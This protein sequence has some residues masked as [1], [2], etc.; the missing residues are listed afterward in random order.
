MENETHICPVCNERKLKLVRNC[1]NVYMKTCGD[2]LCISKKT[3][4]ENFRKYGS[5]NGI[6][7]KKLKQLIIE[8][9]GVEN[10]S[11]IQ[12]IKQKKIET[13]LK[14]FGVE[15]PM[16]SSVV[17]D[18]SKKTIMK[19]YGVDNISKVPEIIE[20]I[21][22]TTHIIDPLT[23]M[24]PYQLGRLKIKIRC[25]EKYGTE[26]YYQTEEFKNKY[27]K[28]MMSKYGVDNYSK[29]KEFGEFLISSGLK[30]D[31]S[32]KTEW[33]KYRYSCMKY[34]RYSYTKY[35]NELEKIY[36]RGKDYHVDHIYSM[37]EGFKNKID[38]KIIGSIVNLQILPSLINIKKQGDCWIS[39]EELNKIYNELSEEDKF[40]HIQL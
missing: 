29:S 27:K 23:G 32:T 40:L 24:T 18:K 17:M 36:P 8:K 13:C 4:D 5:N 26:Y 35:R 21:R 39:I 14:N 19:L 6:D 22:Q 33:D 37:S 10:V 28:T 20:K 34:T 9:Y 2:R 38:P 7:N 16:Q 25:I 11:Q 1:K 31:E 3:Q 15:H 12:S 30:H